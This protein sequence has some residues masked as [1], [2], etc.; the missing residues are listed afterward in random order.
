MRLYTVGLI[1]AAAI[2]VAA[3]VS[4]QNNAF[5]GA[6]NIT[7]DAPDVRGVYWLEVKDEGGKLAALFLNRGGSP[8]PVEAKVT[9]G[10]LSFTLP[11]R[12]ENRPAASFRVSDGKLTGTVGTV[13]VTGVRPPAW[14]ACDA[15]ARHSFGKPVALFDGKS[16]DAWGLALKDRPMGWSIADGV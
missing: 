4:A 3:P 10:Q 7:P 16:L 14:G 15:N 9:D 1:A 12:G 11:G 2:A 6:W 8:V 13:K 5:T